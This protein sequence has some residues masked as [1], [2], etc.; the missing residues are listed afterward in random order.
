[1]LLPPVQMP[2]PDLCEGRTQIGCLLIFVRPR[3]FTL[4]VAC[5]GAAG[6]ELQWLQGIPQRLPKIH[7]NQPSLLPLLLPSPTL[8]W[9]LHL[10]Y[11]LSLCLVGSERNGKKSSSQF[12]CTM[13]SRSG[14]S[15]SF[16]LPQSGRVLDLPLFGVGSLSFPVEYT[17][18]IPSFSPGSIGTPF[19]R[20]VS[21]S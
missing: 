8:Q 17:R 1:M 4:V 21:T 20:T 7:P 9:A 12:Y 3:S 11:A 19:T 13:H 2:S 16:D 5:H 15:L 10:L 18:G 14:T 6:T